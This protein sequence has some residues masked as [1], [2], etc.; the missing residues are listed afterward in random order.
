MAE[1]GFELNISGLE[2]SLNRID[3]SIKSLATTTRN[4][5]NKMIQSISEVVTKGFGALENKANELNKAL[6]NVGRGGSGDK[7]FKETSKSALNAADNIVKMT[8]AIA[9]QGT[10]WQKLQTNINANE[11]EIKRLSALTQ[12]YEQKRASFGSGTGGGVINRQEMQDYEVNKRKLQILQ[13]QNRVWTERQAKIMASSQALSQELRLLQQLQQQ[14]KQRNSFSAAQ[15]D[16]EL[17]RM[18]DFYK[19]VAE[20]KKQESADDK[21]RYEEWLRITHQE[22]Q[23]KK[24]AEKEKTQATKQAIADQNREFK[25]RAEIRKQEEFKKNTSFSGAMAYSQ[26]T[27]SINDQI[28]AIQYLKIARDNLDKSSLGAKEYENRVKAINKEIQRQQEEVNK[29]TGRVRESNNILTK[30]GSQLALLFSVSAIK[31]YVTQLIAVRGEFEMQQRS[32]QVLLKDKSGANKLWQQT[33]D[34]AVKSPFRVKELVSY[35]KQLAA[36]RIES[37]KL[38]DTTRRLADVSAGLGVDMQRLILAFGQVKAASFLRGT[39]LRQ[40]TEAGIPMLEELS[41]YLTEIEGTGVSVGEVFERISKRMISFKD[42]EAVFH[43]MTD[44]GGTF[45]KMQEEQSKTLKGMI[46]N[47]KDSIDLMLNSIGESQEGVLKGSVD[48][49]RRFVENWRLTATI[50]KTVIAAFAMY[51]LNV[52]LTKKALIDYAIANKIVNDSNIKQLSIVNL[53]KLGW[54][55][56]TKTIKSASVATKAFVSKNPIIT[57]LSVLAGVIFKVYSIMKEHKEEI[58]EIN[59]RYEEMAVKISEI[60]SA[61]AN[62]NLEK[63]LVKQRE[64]LKKLLK[65]AEKEYYLNFDFNIEELDKKSI[66][67]AY[68]KVYAEI[69]AQSKFAEDFEKK[70]SIHNRWTMQDDLNEDF[71]ELGESAK[72][73]L[74]ILE[75][76]VLYLREHLI[77]TGKYTEEFKKA[78]APRDVAGGETELAYMERL[79][80]AFEQV[81]GGVR[82]FTEMTYAANNQLV[83]MTIESVFTAKKLRAEWGENLYDGFNKSTQAMNILDSKL[84]EAKKEYDNFIEKVDIPAMLSVSEKENRFKLAID[85]AASQNNWSEFEKEYITRWLNKDYTLN[86]SYAPAKSDNKKGLAEW[87]KQVKPE[88]EK[89][90]NRL[91]TKLQGA[92]SANLFDLPDEESDRDNYVKAI[93][94]RLKEIEDIKTRGK[95][96]GQKIF[97]DEEVYNANVLSK[98]AEELKK[99]LAIIDKPKGGAGKDWY[100][101]LAKGVR[102]YHKDVLKNNKTMKLSAAIDLAKSQN[103]KVL[104]SALKGV[105]LTMDWLNNQNIDFSKEDGVVGL[106]NTI[107]SLPNVATETKHEIEKIISGIT[108]EAI[109][110]LSIGEVESAEKEL[111]NMFSNYEMTMELESEGLDSDYFLDLFGLRKVSAD[112]IQEYI[113]NKLGKLKLTGDFNNDELIKYISENK[114][115]IGEDYA[116]LYIKT[117]E[118][119]NDKERKL[120]QE[121]VKNNMKYAKQALTTIGQIRLSEIQEINAI[122][123]EYDA[124]IERA[125]GDNERIDKLNADRKRALKGVKDK[126]E[127]DVNK[128]LWEEF[129]GS[130]GFIRIFQDA[131]YASNRAIN[132]MLDNLERFRDSLGELDIDELKAVAD[133]MEKL[134]NI[135]MERFPMVEMFKAMG[136]LRQHKLGLDNISTDTVGEVEGIKVG[137]ITNRKQLRKAI[138]KYDKAI[139]DERDKQKGMTDEGAL[140]ASDATIESL[141]KQKKKLEEVE[142]QGKDAYARLKDGFG[143]FGGKIN[144]VGQSL[145]VFQSSLENMGVNFSDGMKDAL[146]TAQEVLGGIGTMAQGIASGNYLQALM[147]LFQTLGALFQIGDKK[148]ER[149]IQDNIKAIEKLGKAYEKLEK[150]I[151]EA[152][153]IDTLQ[154]ATNS[155]MDNLEQQIKKQEEIIALEKAKKKSDE[156]KLDDYRDELDNQMEQLEEMKKEVVSK[157]TN[158]VFDDVLSAADG[159]VDAWL[160]AFKETGDGLKGL[161]DNFNEMML[162]IVKRQASLQI[163]GVFADKW[164]KELEKYVNADDTKLTT[165]E[166]LKFADAVKADMPELSEALKAYFEAMQGVVDLDGSGGDTMSGLQRG[167]E[168]LSEDTGGVIAAYLDSLRFFVSDNNTKL[169]QFLQNYNVTA[170]NYLSPILTQ[171]TNIAD[172]TSAIRSLL[173]SII[174]TYT[175][176][177]GGKAVKIIM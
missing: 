70:L 163:V 88:I 8:N 79:Q 175:G 83:D 135:K 72:N 17:K 47:L 139:V 28:K 167:I 44:A 154:S 62:A 124:K 172:D 92:I 46:S 31:N 148:K 14:E 143:K 140:K 164:K 81:T 55:A 95:V 131:E 157:A 102:E 117:L 82:D 63:N 115:A 39:E 48:L 122:N 156:D 56:L 130:E 169:G 96:K 4:S 78:L 9:K 87:A 75:D 10:T 20:L 160:E 170:N 176:N 25:R 166:A 57:V 86:I 128:A 19:Q 71:N 103:L 51:K 27:K 12:N 120:L 54:S 89:I 73:L 65:L 109:I 119:L 129:K 36:Y 114:E 52:V 105:G 50:L 74:S 2:E 26:Q 64:E 42:V 144:E 125:K 60:N 33:I 29:L 126:S 101:E 13:E 67:E 53:V 121:R 161:E 34:L 136:D 59:K 165:Q 93:E 127:Q 38:H 23:D 16:N 100:L 112:D 18:S 134:E 145:G 35:T 21:K 116:D 84:K 91:K 133:A 171:V 5:T 159:F 173:D 97:T 110:N 150:K 30:F 149:Q 158:G 40:F 138:E 76:N 113:N 85:K 111:E 94:N 68:N 77:Q 90:N 6:S 45:Y 177:A 174:S 61:F 80:K 1:T 22:V 142:E 132:N 98:E 123:N 162:N 7:V 151:E 104:E 32:L 41:Q 3:K 108:G 15:K 99:I 43:R 24:K 153:S 146:G 168:S 118:N 69:Q 66:A 106:L 147:G 155:A 58:D 141:I 152:Y 49:I 107:K 37:D 137:S 11:K